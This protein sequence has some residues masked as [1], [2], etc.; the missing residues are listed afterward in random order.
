MTEGLFI[1]T[2]FFVAYVVYVTVEGSKSKKSSSKQ[3][4]AAPKKPAATKSKPKPTSKPKPSEKKPAAKVAAK[5]TAAKPAEPE[6]PASNELQNPKTGEVATLSS[7][8]RF[9]KRWIKDALVEEGLLP[10]VYKNTEIDDAAAKKIKTAFDK[11]KKM[12]KYRVK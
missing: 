2:A 6:L 9:T 11:I 12:Q 7:N 5:K 1:L 3:P 8:Y 4:A 10:K